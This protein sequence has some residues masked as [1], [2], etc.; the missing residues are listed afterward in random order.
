MRFEC[1]CLWYSTVTPLESRLYSLL[2]DCA[3]QRAH[4]CKIHDTHMV[5]MRSRR[6][7]GTGWQP[8]HHDFEM[9]KSRC[10]R[11]CWSAMPHAY[12]NGKRTHECTHILSSWPIRSAK[13]SFPCCIRHK[14]STYID[15]IQHAIES[16]KI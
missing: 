13:S 10:A 11:V 4:L 12:N 9:K 8:H 3:G 7:C 1:L 15:S 2:V 6:V 16:N 14:R 5:A